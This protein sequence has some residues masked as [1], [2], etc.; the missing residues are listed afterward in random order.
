MNMNGVLTYYMLYY[1]DLTKKVEKEYQEEEV[2][3]VE[4]TGLQ[5]NRNYTI[6]VAACTVDCSARSTPVY[7]MTEIGIPS[8]IQPPTVRFINSSQVKVTWDKPAWPAGP[9]SYYEIRNNE[10]EI[11][12]TTNLGMYCCLKCNFFGF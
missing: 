10:G 5:P 12:N 2:S 3:H 4:L 7:G 1:D 11:L 6:R 8:K 9:L